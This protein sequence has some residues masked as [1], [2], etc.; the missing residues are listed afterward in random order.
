MGP[1]SVFVVDES[2]VIVA[3]ERRTGEER[4]RQ[5]SSNGWL[6]APAIVEDVVVAGDGGRLVAYDRGDGTERWRFDAEA[7]AFQVPVMAAGTIYATVF[8]GVVYGIDPAN[9]TEQWSRELEAR[10]HTPPSAAAGRVYVPDDDAI[11]HALDGETG[12]S[13][14]R[15]PAAGGSL[16]PVATANQVLIPTESGFVAAGPDGSE[17]WRYESEAKIGTPAA[18]PETVYVNE[19]AA[20]SETADN[21]VLALGAADGTVRW[22]EGFGQ[23]APGP[24]YVGGG[25]VYVT[26]RRGYFRLAAG[27]G[28]RRGGEIDPEDPAREYDHPP[29]LGPDHLFVGVQDEALLVALG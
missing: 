13:L 10:T 7:D 17:R 12:E 4:W 9:G 14:W 27:D 23:T 8:D 6:T 18:G 16:P 5:H 3:L 25:T 21:R 28:T 19:V 20:G 1:E 15:A 11:L 22:E 29:S 2:G 26:S 24:V